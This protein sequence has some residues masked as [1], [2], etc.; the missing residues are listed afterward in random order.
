[1]NSVRSEKHGEVPKACRQS[2]AVR[3]EACTPGTRD[4]RNHG[5]TPE[6]F[7]RQCNDF[8]QQRRKSQ[9]GTK[10]LEADALLTLDEVIAVRLYSGPAY[11]PINH[12]L[13]EV[14]RLSD[15]YQQRLAR[16][17]M[18]TFASTVQHIT[19]AVRKL[20]AV[21][22]PE[23]AVQPLYRGV[24][25]ELPNGFWVPDKAGYI[26]AVEMGF[27]S[28][29]RNMETPINYMER[30]GTNILWALKPGLETDEA[31]H[32]GADVS[33]LS[34]F[35][36]EAEVLFPPCTLLLL[37]PPPSAASAARALL[38]GVGRRRHDDRPAALLH[39]G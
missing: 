31:F 16:H 26:C 14:S 34:Q 15:D 3:K 5:K 20:S 17:P 32:R 29:S 30:N 1:M 39:H 38:P 35:E 23:E 19:N 9:Y 37:P 21:V 12:F 2:A 33:M 11:Q 4:D 25:G 27:M 24:R 13:R 8:I 6:D 10:L 18:L 22:T 28:T 7:L 36:S